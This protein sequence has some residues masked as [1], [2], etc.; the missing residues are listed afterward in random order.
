MKD[1]RCE[2]LPEGYSILH[3]MYPEQRALLQAGFVPHLPVG[4]LALPV[5]PASMLH[6]PNRAQIL[7][8]CSGNMWLGDEGPCSLRKWAV[9]PH[10]VTM[11]S[12]ESLTPCAHEDLPGQDPLV[13]PGTWLLLLA[14]QKPRSGTN[15]WRRCRTRLRPSARSLLC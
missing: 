7:P 12:I 4:A 15:A 10:K 13:A 9:I 1:Y 3:F 5:R 14:F 6:S 11:G 2:Y 8:S